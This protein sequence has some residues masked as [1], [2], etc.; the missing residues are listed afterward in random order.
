MTDA[1]RFQLVSALLSGKRL[2]Y[3]TLI[4]ATEVPPGDGTNEG[5]SAALPN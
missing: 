3:K 1:E 2:T 4:G 5:E